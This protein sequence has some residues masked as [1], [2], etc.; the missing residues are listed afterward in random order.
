MR[1]GSMT[2]R[3]SVEAPDEAA[4]H[5]LYVADLASSYG[6]TGAIVRWPVSSDLAAALEVTLRNQFAEH[7]ADRPV[8]EICRRYASCSVEGMHESLRLA[9]RHVL[10]EPLR[11]QG[12]ELGAGCGL[13]ASVVAKSPVVQ[14]VLAVEVC[15]P[16]VELLIP[17]VARHVLGLGDAAKVVPVVGSFDDLNLPNASLDFAVEY[18]SYHHSAN[19]ESTIAE[20]A[21]VLRPGG[22]VLLFDRIQPDSMPDEEVARLLSLVYPRE[23]LVAHNYPLDLPLTRAM[24]GEHEYRLHE[25]RAAIARAGLLL[26]HRLECRPRIS[27]ADPLAGMFSF[28]PTPVR[29]RLFRSSHETGKTTRRWLSQQIERALGRAIVGLRRESILLLRKRR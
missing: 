14:A 10:T 17:K 9:E 15:P 4:R 11:G 20:T 23:F 12:I 25:W 27:S 3:G 19:L 18:H 7:L 16:Q 21:R 28:L 5:R 22:V 26:E 29:E 2:E 13:L 24:N 1:A 8:R 6:A